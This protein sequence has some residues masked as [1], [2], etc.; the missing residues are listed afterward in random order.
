MPKPKTR[1]VEMYVGR[2]EP[3]DWYVLDIDVPAYTP[4]DKNAEAAGEAMTRILNKGSVRAPFWG[5]YHVPGGADRE[6]LAEIAEPG[7]TSPEQAVAEMGKRLRYAVAQ[8][9]VFVTSHMEELISLLEESVSEYLQD[10]A[11]PEEDGEPRFAHR[12]PRLCPFCRRDLTRPRSVRLIFSLSDG[13]LHETASQLDGTGLLEDVDGVVA[14]GY[15]N[16]TT[17]SECGDSL[18][19]HER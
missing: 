18:M 8:T 13:T 9:G 3:R 2:V 7:K 17:C 11:D 10:A 15:H 16:D 5:L 6:A 4:E 14:N 12:Y 19:E 1:S